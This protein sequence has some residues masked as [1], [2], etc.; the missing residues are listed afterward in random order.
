[1][2]QPMTLTTAE[3]NVMECLWDKSPQT[4]RDVVSHMEGTMDWSRSTTL[5]LLTRLEA[6]GAV[7]SD[8][9]QGKKLFFPLIGRQEVARQET[10][11]FLDRVYQGSLSMMLS[12]MTQGATLSKKELEQLQSLLETMEG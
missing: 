2:R 6:K 1:M 12:T 5:T 3:W 10:K 4:G 8:A 9:T 11:A 7:K